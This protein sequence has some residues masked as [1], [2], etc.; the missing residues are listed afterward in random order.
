MV[1]FGKILPVFLKLHKFISYSF[2]LAFRC[3]LYCRALMSS[4]FLKERL[5]LIGK[6]GCGLCVVGSTVMV[7]HSP[8]ETKVHSMDV[9]LDKLQEPGMSPLVLY[10]NLD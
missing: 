8:Q 3:P 1:S 9:L 6:V 7:L 4:A 2:V 5:N 10:T